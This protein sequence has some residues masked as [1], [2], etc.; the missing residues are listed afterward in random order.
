MCGSASL[1]CKQDR[2]SVWWL[3]GMLGETG[4]W[5]M[6]PIRGS[7]DFL[8]YGSPSIS[9][10]NARFQSPWK[11]CRG[12]FSMHIIWSHMLMYVSRVVFRRIIAQVFLSGHVIN[13]EIFLHFSVQ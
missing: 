8:V 11:D 2:P 3:G 7:G 5:V 1:L 13:F 6:G 9:S 4:R 12:G 10:P